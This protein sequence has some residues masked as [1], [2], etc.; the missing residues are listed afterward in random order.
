VVQLGV[1][2]KAMT[3]G[4]LFWAERLRAGPAAEKF[5]E[6]GSLA[7]KRNWA[8]SENGVQKDAFEFI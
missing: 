5:K 7:T 3:P 8:E 4:G 2:R 6:K 1:Q